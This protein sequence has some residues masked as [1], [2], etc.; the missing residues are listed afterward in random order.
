MAREGDPPPDATDLS[1]LTALAEAAAAVAERARD[2]DDAGRLKDDFVSI[3]SHELRAPIAVVH[4]IAATLHARVDDLQRD[5]IHALLGQLVVQTDRLRAWP[6]SCSTCLGSSEVERQARASASTR[7]SGC[8]SSC[9]GS[10]ASA[11]PTCASWSSPATP[12]SPTRSPSS[13]SRPTWS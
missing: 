6:T 8:T 11:P 4:G 12:W 3:A 13:G 10:P 1:V 5:Q 2:V 7:T 9:R